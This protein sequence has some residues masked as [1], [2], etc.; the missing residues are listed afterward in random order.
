MLTKQITRDIQSL[1]SWRKKDKRLKIRTA[2]QDISL[3]PAYN[4]DHRSNLNKG[5]FQ[6]SHIY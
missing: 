5:A 4:T 3:C 2:Q 1:E 6:S